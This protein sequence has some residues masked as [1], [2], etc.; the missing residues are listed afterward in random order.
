MKKKNIPLLAIGLFLSAAIG[1]VLFTHAQAGKNVLSGNNFSVV[2]A[3]TPNELTISEA[4]DT[5]NDYAQDWKSGAEI[6]SLDSIDTSDD[7]ATA[8][9]D[10]KRRIWRAGLVDPSQTDTILWVLLA[11]GKVT[12][13]GKQPNAN[14]TVPLLGN[15]TINSP[16]ALTIAQSAKPDFTSYEG[17]GVGFDF[18]LGITPDGSPTI[19]I[20]G[21]YQGFPA[22]VSIDANS[23]TLLQAVH[24]AFESGGILYSN[25]DGLTWKASDLSGKMVTGIATNPLT[26]DQAYAIA[27]DENQISLYRTLNGGENWSLVGSLPESAGNWPYDI[28]TDV[29][30]S[31]NTLILV[32]TISDLWSSKDGKDWSVVPGLPSGPKQWIASIST[33]SGSKVFVSITNGENTGLYT[34]TDLSTWSKL[35]D[36][37]YR[38]SKSFDFQSVLAT[39]EELNQALLLTTE[40]KTTYKV[41]EASLRGAGD[42][43]NRELT[44]IESSTAGVGQLNQSGVKWTLSQPIASLASGP[45]YPQSH[46]VVAG[47]FRTGLYRSSDNG[48]SWTVVLEDPSTVLKGSGEI[49][50]VAYLSKADVI[51][52]NGG[53][54]KWRDF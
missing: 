53:E 29:D 42:F 41:P 50:D 9:Q 3:S 27:A 25:D 8:G 52:V 36:K 31:G 20:R 7:P 16:E 46:V 12:Q 19:S 30:P 26:E 5:I 18:S 38:F 35:A 39:N 37:A 13:E 40:G 48:E 1:G 47:G 22:V 44:V 49:T 28:E 4:W 33:Q 43:E 2:E 51:A 10:G 23:G 15:F 14:E 54:L 11:D 32:G 24:I 17:K 6:V 34:S 21:T 45:N